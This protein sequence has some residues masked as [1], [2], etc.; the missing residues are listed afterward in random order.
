MKQ[1]L[2]WMMLVGMSM[3]AACSEKSK[4]SLEV[5][6]TITHADEVAALYPKAVNN[7]NITL[8]LYEVPFGGELPPAQLDSV[9]IPAS[10]KTFTL[11]AKMANPGLYNVLVQNGPMLPLVNDASSITLDID[12]A[13]KEKFYTVKGSSASEQLRDFIFTYSDRRLTIEQLG[14][15]A[16]SLKRSGAA[17]SVVLVAAHKKDAAISKLNS[18]LKKSLAT[19][20]QPIV[21]TF[22]LGRSAQT[23]EQGEF[24]TELGKL[25]QRFP[26]DANITDLKKRYELYKAQKAEMEK[27]QQAAAERAAANS[28]VGKKA[29]ELVLPDANGKNISLAS[30]KGKYV[31]VDFWASWCGP[32]RAEN[33]HV[34]A[35]YNRFKN[36]NFT[37]LGVSLDQKKEDWLKAVE[38]D[39]LTWTH[40]SDLAF[41]KSKAVD[42][43]KFEGIPFNVLVD[44]QGKIIGEGLRGDALEEKLGEVLE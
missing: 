5:N 3:L 25:T 33:P 14:A 44:P 24:E 11:K 40:V 35:A 18:W 12:L 15:A 8:L 21:A 2:Y 38:K 7:G 1:T 6:G 27:Q 17:D 9:T 43:F 29:P 13:T 42:I 37:I 30:F 36:K 34:V 19:I 31:L 41:W 10:Q 26:D 28:W 22:A 32:C 23:L 39:G 4:R 16:D 20:D